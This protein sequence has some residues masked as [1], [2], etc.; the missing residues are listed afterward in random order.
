MGGLEVVLIFAAAFVFC[1]LVVTF[2]VWVGW[3]LLAAN[4]EVS[5]G[6]ALVQ[7]GQVPD[8][9]PSSPSLVPLLS[10]DWVGASTYSRGFVNDDQAS[11]R[12]QAFDRPGTVLA[13]SAVARDRFRSGRIDAVGPGRFV[14]D[15][16]QGFAR[17]TRDGVALGAVHL[18]SGAV[19]DA[20]GQR[21]G[22]LVRDARA[23]A[24][25]GLDDGR[26]GPRVALVLGGAPT[27]LLDAS[28][29]SHQ[30]RPVVLRP[31][32]VRF[33]PGAPDAEAWT[34][35]ACLLEVA[36]FGLTRTH[37]SIRR[38]GLGVP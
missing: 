22:R 1:A 27:A 2:L 14:L 18:E 23:L 17:V 13:F 15:V 6:A 25:E 20:A 19:T 7:S 32:V 34:L 35:V 36:W 26:S 4:R 21:L 28:S 37:A 5:H 8:L 29:A 3:T 10:A 30:T 33:Q 11:G 31:L 38:P 12:L 24:A 16:S 9:L